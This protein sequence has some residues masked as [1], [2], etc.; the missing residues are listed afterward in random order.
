MTETPLHLFQAVGIEL[1]YMIVAHDTLSVLPVSDKILA[2]AA[3]EIVSEIEMG[4]VSWSNELVM[5]VIELKT[6]GPAPRL[7]GLGKIFFEHV[8]KVNALLEPLG[9]RLMPTASHPWM[10]PHSETVLWPHEYSVVY[11]TYDRIFGCR[12]HG[13]SNLQSTHVNLP[14]HGDE[15]FGRLHAAI[16]LLMPIM[17]ALTAASPILDGKAT[18]FMDSRME[19]YR[20]NSRRIASVAGRIIPEPVYHQKG[21]ET[22][23]F[24]RMYA[25]IAPFDPE[26]VLQHEF[27]NSRGAIARFDRGAIEIRV[28]DIQETPQADVAIVGLITAV[29]KAL[30]AKQGEALKKIQTIDTAYLAEL[31]LAVIKDAER[32]RIESGLYLDLL[33]LSAEGGLTAGQIWR[34]LY[35]ASFSGRERDDE[36]ARCLEVILTEGCLARRISRS[37]GDGWDKD[38]LRRIYDRLCRCLANGEMFHG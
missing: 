28:L 11:E 17:P 2:A 10:D 30:C 35:E 23:I 9:G 15:E 13:W 36:M 16:R 34:R 1:E 24:Q 7:S 5:H 27:L 26:G 37:L 21:Y 31:F 20:H 32:T 19:V 3:G 25:D 12:G 38:T 22:E 29:L 18:G 6:N 4:P 8:Q 14:F 33:G